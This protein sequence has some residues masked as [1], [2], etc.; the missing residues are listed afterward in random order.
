MPCSQLISGLGTDCNGS[1]GG[2]RE[3]L[4]ANREDLADVLVYDG[5]VYWIDMVNGTPFAHYTFREGAASMNSTL[6]KGQDYR[7]VDTELTISF[8]RMETV[9]RT[10]LQ[11]F[12][13]GE[14]VALVK[15]GNGRWWMLGVDDAVVATAGEGVTG[16]GATDRNGYAVTFRDR[17]KAFPMEVPDEVVASLSK[18]FNGDFNDDFTILT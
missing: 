8:L 17:S 12:I 16:A 18:D 14:F 7:F 2:I 11:A 13:S 10:E 6:Q 3:V 9:K 15:D 1:F 4:L 5:A